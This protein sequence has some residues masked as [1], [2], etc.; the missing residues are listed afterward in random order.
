[1]TKALLANKAK[2]AANNWLRPLNCLTAY[3]PTDEVN[4]DVTINSTLFPMRIP[5][6]KMMDVMPINPIRASN[7]MVRTMAATVM[8]IKYSDKARFSVKRKARPTSIVKTNPIS[9]TIR[10][11]SKIGVRYVS[12]NVKKKDTMIP[13]TRMRPK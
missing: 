9:I 11:S 1:M 5:T 6:S 3:I 2:M 12:K 7:M 4:M 13:I 8:G 10:Q